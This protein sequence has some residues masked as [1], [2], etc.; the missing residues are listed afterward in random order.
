MTSGATPFKDMTDSLLGWASSAEL[1]LGEALAANPYFP[2]AGFSLDQLERYDRFFGIFLSRQLI[3]GSDITELLKVT[4]ALVTTTMISRAARMVDEDSF[5]AE[6]LAGLGVDATPEWVAAVEENAA[7]I[8]KNAGVEYPDAAKT[9]IE[10]LVYQAGITAAEIPAI[11]ELLDSLDTDGQ[12]AADTALAAI[13]A[14][15]APFT[16]AAKEFAPERTTELLAG[17]QVLRAFSVTHPTSWID[18]TNQRAALHPQLPILIAEPLVAELRE[19]PVGTSERSTA[20]GVGTRELRPRAVLDTNR[21][22]VCI[23]L[24]EQRVATALGAAAQ[25]ADV[26]WRVS[27]GGTTRIFRT[28]RPWGEPT[29]A[30][31][32]DVAVSHQVRDVTVADTTNAISWVV[33]LVDVDDPVLI[34]TADGLNISDKASLH[35]STLYIFSPADARLVDVV[36]SQ[37]VPVIEELTIQGWDSWICRK[38][39]VSTCASLQAIR[40]GQ[41]PTP[42]DSLRAIDPRQ[43]VRFSAG[44]EGIP[45]V[46]THT[47]R[48]VHASSLI[49]E[50]PPTISGGDEEWHLSIS[51]YARAGE[52]AEEIA[53][54]EALEVPAAGGAFLVFDPE[55]YDSPWVGEYMVR[56]RGPRNES[57]RYRYAIVE[58]MQVETTIEGQSTSVRIPMGGGLSPAV[59][60]IY[61]G[62][63]PFEASPRKVVVPADAAAAE[64]IISTEEGDQLP[65]RFVPPALK[66]ELALHSYLPMWRTSRLFVGSRNFDATGSLRIRANGELGRPRVSVRNQHGSPVRTVALTAE[67]AVT[68]AAPLA[69]IAQTAAVMPEGRLDFEWTDLASGN[70]VS[71]ALALISSRPHATE[72]VITDGNIVFTDLSEGRNLG[73]WIWPVTAPWIQPRT[74]ES[75]GSGTV[76]LPESLID[77]GPLLVQ[78]HSADP[79]SVLRAPQ[80]PGAEV[81]RIEQAGYFKDQPEK[82]AQL[83]AFFAE[84]T[85]QP[86]VSTDVLPI[87]WDHFGAS[88]RQREVAQS[89]FQDNPTAALAALSSSLVPAHLQPGLMIATGLVNYVFGQTTDTELIDFK[90]TTSPWITTMALLG[91]VS[92]GLSAGAEDKKSVQTV[93]KKLKEIAGQR[94]VDTLLT[95]RDTTLDSAVIDSSTVRIA[96]MDAAQQKQLMNMFFASAEIVP[97]PIMDDSARLLAVFETFQQREGL[98]AIVASEGLIKPAVSL[99]RALRSSHRSLY[100]AARIRF[101]KLDGVNTEDRANAWVLAPVVSMIFALSARLHAHGMMGKS[102]TLDAAAAGWSQLADLVP[103]L[104]TGDLISAD[105]MVLAVKQ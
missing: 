54:P 101:D 52:R 7:S 61:Q 1:Q 8:L 19:R 97:G 33:P 70:R 67:D 91:E 105:A 68:Y 13:T 55:A 69:E 62:D 73:A 94:L 30:E 3:A 96:H 102:S 58:G 34:F 60:R 71:V 81:I 53:E 84:E 89:I 6:Y 38:V 65:L 93:L 22:R 15:I 32:L 57:F 2:R 26:S 27:I 43:R 20:V 74:I 23:R 104:V 28:N 18:R 99:L 41:A 98:S 87:I 72:A 14:D 80:D 103:D 10:V 47:G 95:G 77:A 85:E 76:A 79:F 39:D 90:E 36:G 51:A 78:L 31:A 83:S 4:P 5:F 44:D 88:P 48:A 25:E 100:A 40:P 42:G 64:F 50:F 24:P 16:A 17:V 11:L 29:Y 49:V 59:A 56:V 75:I 9:P 37:D 82:L 12:T 21:G 92:A 63:K 86:P 66:F 46:F 35:Y 45:S